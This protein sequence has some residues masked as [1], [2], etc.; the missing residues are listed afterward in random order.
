MVNLRSAAKRGPYVNR[1]SDMRP[2]IA[3]HDKVGTILRIKSDPAQSHLIK[4]NI[5]RWL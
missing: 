4:V 5:H 1:T 2:G 3:A